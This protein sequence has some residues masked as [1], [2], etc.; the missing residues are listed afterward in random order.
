MSAFTAETAFVF[1]D[2][3]NE[4]VDSKGKLAGKGYAKFAE[5]NNS[6]QNTATL[7]NNARASGSA[8]IHVRIGFSPDYKEQPENSPLFGAAKKFGALK[9]GDWGTE[10][11]PLVSP[12][13]D[14]VVIVKHRVSPFYGTPLNLILKTYG[15]KKLVLSGCATDVAVQSAARDAHDRDYAC[16]V[17]ADCCIAASEDDHHQALRMLA[18][19]ASIQQVDSLLL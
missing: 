19:V 13:L 12:V 3:I 2:F 11:H 18:K 15:V 9:L 4:I 10:F 16:I 17:A 14:E 6:L 1:I 7:L 5:A 8:I